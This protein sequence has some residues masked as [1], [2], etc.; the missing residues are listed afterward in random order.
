MKEIITFLIAA[1]PV[2]ELRASI[3][4][5]TGLFLM[6]PI[7]AFYF[8]V[9]GNLFSVVLLA[10][11]LP[12]VSSFLLKHSIFAKKHLEN[13]YSKTRKKHSKR[14][15]TLGSLGLFILTAVPFPF[16]G[17]WTASLVAFI[18]KLPFR[19]SFFAIALGVIVA[20]LLVSGLMQGIFFLF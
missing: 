13:L 8:S 7:K 15:E 1:T 5:A 20:G 17:A 14:I 9:L 18:F 11:F 10:I 19:K 3:P 2:F 4:I 6:S 16:T 12:K